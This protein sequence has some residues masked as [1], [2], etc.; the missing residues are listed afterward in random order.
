MNTQLLKNGAQ[1]V[2]LFFYLFYK[3][4]LAMFCRPEMYENTREKQSLIH[5]ILN[6]IIFL[7]SQHFS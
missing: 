7:V 3:L 6:H 5:I 2:F 4:S 1:R